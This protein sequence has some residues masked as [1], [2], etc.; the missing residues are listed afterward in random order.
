M[1]KKIF[2]LVCI[3]LFF[4]ASG[5][6]LSADEFFGAV[7][8]ALN[9]V[10]LFILIKTNTELI[11]SEERLEDMREA[12]FSANNEAKDAKA[13][14]K[15]LNAQIKKYEEDTP[16]RGKNGK[17]VKRSVNESKN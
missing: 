10:W 15:K 13:Q 11:S 3:A 6:C 2:Y 14:I 8:S 1:K 5:L 4:V 16:A 9:I 17:F 12:A 7:F